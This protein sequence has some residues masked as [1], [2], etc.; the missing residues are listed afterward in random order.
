MPSTEPERIIH[1][2]AGVIVDGG[3]VFVTRR[4]PGAHLEGKWE[5]PGG[6]VAEGET[7]HAA[8][9]RE[10]AEETGIAVHRA[11]PYVRIQHHYAEKGVLLDVWR[12]DDYKGTPHGREGQEAQWQKISSL[13]PSAFPAAD[14]LVIRQLQLPPL[15]AISAATRVGCVHWIGLLKQALNAGLQL[16]QVREP[17]LQQ[18]EFE[19]L[20]REVIDLCHTHNAQVLINGSPDQAL[21]LGADGVHLNSTRLRACLNRPL[22]ENLLVGA[23]CHNAEELSQAERAG[24]DLVVLGPVMPT[25]SHAHATPLG[26]DNFANLCASTSVPVYALGGIR[27]ED[28]IRARRVGAHGVAMISALWEGNDAGNVVRLCQ[29]DRESE[30]SL[31]AR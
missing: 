19:R 24:A 6:K 29:A 30:R 18:T 13:Q 3:R 12:I 26:W 9:V 15:Y 2:V 25:A 14:R 8:L 20:A 16:V 21:A 27:T 11:T 28:A 5:F 31:N 23:S 1:V 10:L 22:P 17:G 7:V 4:P